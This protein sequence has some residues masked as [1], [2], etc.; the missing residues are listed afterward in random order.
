M[1]DG[2]RFQCHAHDSPPRSELVSLRFAIWAHAAIFDSRYSHLS[3]KFYLQARKYIEATEAEAP[4]RFFTVPALQALILLALY[5]FKQACFTRSWVSVSRATWLAQSLGLHKM[6]I[7]KPEALG[8]MLNILPWTDDSMEREERRRTFWVM[9][10]LNCLSTVGICWNLGLGFDHDEITTHLPVDYPDEVNPGKGI[11]LGEALKTSVAGLLCPLQG[12][13]LVSSLSIRSVTHVNQVHKEHSFDAP[14]YDFWTHHHHLNELLNHASNSTL[15]HLKP[16]EGK[17]EP[18]VVFIN[19]ILQSS[20]ICLHQ[21]VIYRISRVEKRTAPAVRLESEQRCFEAVQELI[22]AVRYIGQVSTAKYLVRREQAC[23]QPNPRVLPDTPHESPVT[24]SIGHHHS[25]QA[26]SNTSYRFGAFHTKPSTTSLGNGH[27]APSRQSS[28]K[29]TVDSVRSMD[30]MHPLRRRL[31]ALKVTIP[32]ARVF[33]AQIEEEI[34][35]GEAVT[36]ERLVG[37]VRYLPRTES[38]LSNGNHVD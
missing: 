7:T 22:S 32:L 23:S 17:T 10:Q 2:H 16:I 24:P 6:D 14:G 27:G 28:A 29:G 38:M 19:V 34:E 12:T 4:S 13:A 18:N 11:T 35:G 15:A 5:E 30:W 1:I 21:A 20:I 8:N 37:F 33:E 31:G 36:R 25:R 3:D 9:L 26:S